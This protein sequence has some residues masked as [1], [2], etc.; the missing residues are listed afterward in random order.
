MEQLTQYRMRI[1]II[2]TEGPPNTYE[3]ELDPNHYS[4]SAHFFSDH[5]PL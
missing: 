1:G 5:R 2:P 3:D 4:R